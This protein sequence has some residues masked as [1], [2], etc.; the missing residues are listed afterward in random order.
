MQH[1]K[2]TIPTGRNVNTVLTNYYVNAME[3]SCSKFCI[4]NCITIDPTPRKQTNTGEITLI[5]A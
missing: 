5:L 4:F 1:F 3:I 2:V